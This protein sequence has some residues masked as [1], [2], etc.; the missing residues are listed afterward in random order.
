MKRCWIA[1]LFLM[2]AGLGML[3]CGSSKQASTAPTIPTSAPTGSW[4]ITS[5]DN[6]GY[7]NTLQ[8]KF[9]SILCEPVM[10]P[11]GIRL[12]PVGTSCSLADNLTG[13]GSISATSGY[14]IGSPQILVLGVG[15]PPT[16][17][18]ALDFGFVQADAHG[19][20]EEKLGKGTYIGTTITGTWQCE[21]GV[22]SRCFGLS[23]TFTA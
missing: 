20:L 13:Q 16:N 17:D 12:I 11:T 21:V 3:D 6:S 8:A 1:F 18:S 10:L 5:I 14:F 15:A 4:V 9:V 2:L 7:S 19:D 22:S 23:G